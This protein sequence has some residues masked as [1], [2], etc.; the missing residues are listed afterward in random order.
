[1]IEPTIV[2]PNADK[3]RDLIDS[4]E[5][6]VVRSLMLLVYGE[7]LSL[8]LSGRLPSGTVDLLYCFTALRNAFG[9]KDALLSA[10]N[11]DFGD[12]YQEI[13]WT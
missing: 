10:L 3:V 6:H 13:E 7:F 8:M 2:F 11:G 4:E 5:D 12:P 9:R 1:M